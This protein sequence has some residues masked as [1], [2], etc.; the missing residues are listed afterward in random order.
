MDTVMS[1]I[2]KAD[3]CQPPGMLLNPL[4]LLKLLRLD[5]NGQVPYIQ[6]CRDY[7]NI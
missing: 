2:L 6:I 5:A 3:L 4:L 1:I 7:S